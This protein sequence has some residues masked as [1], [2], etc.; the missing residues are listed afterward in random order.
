MAEANLI[1]NDIVANAKATSSKINAEADAYAI[2]TLTETERNNAELI[3]KAITMEGQI[4]E[5][6]LQGSKKKRKHLQIME[7]LN[8][9]ES[10]ANNKKMVI[11]GEQGNNLLANLE[12]FKM[13]QGKWSL[14]R[15]YHILFDI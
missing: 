4:E 15:Y 9:M 5:K 13:V 2:K 6:M 10:L 1:E 3:S 7:R 14:S 12:S 11:Y 8:A